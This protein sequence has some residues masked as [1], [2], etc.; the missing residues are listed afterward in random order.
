MG[1]GQILERIVSRQLLR[2]LLLLLRLVVVLLL[3]QLLPSN[4]CLF[5]FHCFLLYSPRFPRFILP[6]RLRRVEEGRAA[7]MDAR[8]LLPKVALARRLAQ[9]AAHNGNDARIELA[10]KDLDMHMQGVYITIIWCGMLCG[11]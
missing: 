5:L 4:P 1:E 6:L 11:A 8:A 10:V 7:M 9:E 2:L 3:L